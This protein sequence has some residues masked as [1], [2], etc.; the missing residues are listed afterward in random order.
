MGGLH[1][2]DIRVKPISLMADS[3]HLGLSI[4]KSFR[5]S[6]GNRHRVPTW[7]SFIQMGGQK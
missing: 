5:K 3:I 6:H 7:N 2:T 4:S 1:A